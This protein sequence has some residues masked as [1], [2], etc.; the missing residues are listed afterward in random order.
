MSV[1]DV[2][3]LKVCKILYRARQERA[4]ALIERERV[5]TR[6]SWS[7]C[8][9]LGWV[10]NRILLGLNIFTTLR[11]TSSMLCKLDYPELS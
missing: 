10:V 8:V 4:M 7:E 9:G 3:A 11:V 6:I 2:L 1:T 5:E